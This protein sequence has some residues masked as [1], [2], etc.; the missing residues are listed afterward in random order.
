MTLRKIQL[1]LLISLSLFLTSCENDSRIKEQL[2]SYFTTLFS[3]PIEVKYNK[4]FIRDHYAFS[5][6]DFE[7]YNK[8][9]D[10][11][12]SYVELPD[13]ISVEDK[14]IIINYAN[15]QVNSSSQSGTIRLTSDAP[16]Y[17]EMF[18]ITFNIPSYRNF[19]DVLML[20]QFNS[21][22][23]W[24]GEVYS[25]HAEIQRQ[26]ITSGHFYTL[27]TYSFYFET[28]NLSY[29][30]KNY[31]HNIYGNYNETIEVENYYFCDEP[32]Y[33]VEAPSQSLTK[34]VKYLQS[35]FEHYQDTQYL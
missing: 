28:G 14:D 32:Y 11:D 5:N 22:S 13:A 26:S 21:K 10:I 4:Q 17:D 15:L 31:E 16:K 35:V 19:L 33:D 24:G 25:D 6:G 20:T 27:W 18:T 1:G 7:G 12:A 34:M 9:I 8:P 3:E 23:G 2:N 29:S 30:I